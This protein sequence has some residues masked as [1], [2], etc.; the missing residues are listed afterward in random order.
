MTLVSKTDTLVIYFGFLLIVIGFVNSSEEG[1][2][3]KESCEENESIN[4]VKVHHYTKGM[5]LF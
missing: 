3:T 2:C 1:F 4:D 5:C